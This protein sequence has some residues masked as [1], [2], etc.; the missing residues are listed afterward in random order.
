MLNSAEDRAEAL[1]EVWLGAREDGRPTEFAA[2]LAEHPELADELT[3]CHEGWALLEEHAESSLPGPLLPGEMGLGESRLP[4]ATR[5][6]DLKRTPLTAGDTVGEFKLLR[7]L[8]QGG[9]GSVWEAEQTTLGRRVALKLLRPGRESALAIERLLVEARAAGRADHP[10][11]V[12][13]FAA[14]EADGHH[15][16]AQQL[17][18]EGRSLVDLIDDLRDEPLLGTDD[19]RKLAVFFRD[20]ARAVH[21]AHEAGVLHRDLK[22]Q[23][24][25]VNTKGE[26]KLLDFGISKVLDPDLGGA[27]ATLSPLRLLTPE[28]ASPEQ[29]RGQLVTTASDVY[30]I[31]VVC[32]EALAGDRPYQ[33]QTRVQHE[34]ERALDSAK[35]APPSSLRA[36]IPRDL[37]AIL[38]KCLRP[39]PE[40]RYAGMAEL[41]E[42]LRCLE[43]GLPVAARQ[44]NFAY[45]TARY[46][47]RYRALVAG[48]AAILIAITLGVTSTLNQARIAAERGRTAQRVSQF[49]VRLFHNADPWEQGGEDVPVRRILDLGV[50]EIMLTLQ[51]EP[52]ERSVLLRTLGEV[53]LNLGDENQAMALLGEAEKLLSEGR[54]PDP[55]LLGDT[56]HHLGVAMRKI[57]DLTGASDVQRRA[58]A[59]R[60]DAFGE[61]SKEAASS[62]NTLGLVYHLNGEFEMA[63][64]HYNRALEL[65]RKLLLPSHHDI[66]TTLSNLASLALA[67]E[68]TEEALQLFRDALSIQEQR[69]SDHPDLAT[70]HNNLGK[71]LQ[72]AEEYSAAFA[73]LSI[74]LEMRLELLGED[75]PHVAGSLSNL[76][77]V[78]YDRGNYPAAEAAFARALT[79]V[80]RRLPNDHPLVETILYNL[81]AARNPPK[82]DDQG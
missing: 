60:R 47:R 71:G 31:G 20:V 33:M 25:L 34:I 64:E 2:L 77:S 70:A 11:L 82:E 44:G 12:A 36:D 52:A 40:A 73:E 32:F 78:E 63:E 59:T 14:G 42:D 15:Y 43:R 76:G 50:E 3:A 48:I 53:Y 38:L 9:M 17:V 1:F 26:P 65:R 67:R 46:L 75:H 55:E 8:G 7:E 28:Y 41:D 4:G 29:V 81:D 57:G 62:W 49:L 27:G 19:Y 22:P 6:A 45:L 68:D 18:G 10:G 16:I 58:L 61:E 5:R 37:D 56:L 69:G 24:I 35:V 66:A 72:A 54:R 74:A 23:N 21:A 39:E 79:V 30:S 51:D 13:V 80:Q